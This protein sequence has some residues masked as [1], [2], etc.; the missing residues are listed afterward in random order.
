MSLNPNGAPAGYYYQAGATAYLVDPAGTYSVAGATAPTTD[1]VGAYSGAGASAPTLAAAGTYIPVTGATS[2][3]EAIVDPAGT[4]SAAAASAP[5]T[6]PTGTYSALGASAPTPAAPGAYIPAAGA[7]SAG[8]QTYSPPGTYR[9]PGASAPIADPGGT[10]SGPDATAPTMDPAGT[11]SSSYA[12]DRVFLEGKNLTPANTVLAFNNATAVANYYGATSKEA[13]QAKEFFAGYGN[14]SA[15]MLFTRYSATR[16]PHLLGANI[17]GLTLSQL[18]SISGSLALTFQGYTYSGSINLAQ[19]QSFSEV[20]RT[21]QTAL[22]KN[23]QFAA[24]TEGSSITPVSVT[25]TGSI[26]GELLDVTSISSGSIELGAEISGSGVP[27]GNQ[28]VTQLNGTPGGPGLYSF[29]QGEGNVSSET[30]TESYGVLTVGTVESGTVGVGQFVTGT[31]VLPL[32]AIDGNLSGSGPGSTWLVN[33]AQMVAGESMTMTAPPITVI[34]NR[35]GKT[36]TGATENNDFFDVT[37]NGEF[38]YDNNSGSLSFMSGTA[39]AALGLTQASGAIDS[40]PGGLH[41]SPAQVMNLIVQ[42]EDSQFGSFQSNNGFRPGLAAWAQSTDGVYTFLGQTTDTLPAG[43]SLPT[44]DPAGTYSGPGASAPTPAAPGTYIPVTGATSSA[45]EITDS[46]GTYSLAGAS[47]PTLARPGFYVPTA[48][49]SFETPVSPGYYQPHAGATRE[50]L[51][52]APTI[53]GT[54]AGQSTPSGQTDAPFSS[55]TIADRNVGASD[56]LTIQITGGGG[57]L[58]DG[59]GFSGLTESTAGVYLLT[60][61]DSAI[62]SELDALV[63]TPN[64]FDATTTFTLAD[65]T[66]LGTTSGANANTTVT[67]TNG[68][69]VYSVS[70]F[71]ADQTILDLIPGGF[72]I[73]DTAADISSDLDQ[74]DDSHIDAIAISDNGEVSASV[75]QLTNDKTAIGKLQNANLST[76]LLAIQDT[77]ADVQAGLST[78]VAKSTE[79]ASITASNGPVVVSA[80]TVQADQPALDKIVGGFAVSDTANDVVANLNQLNDP[81]IS[82][83]TISDNGQISVS[84]AQLTADATAIGKLENANAS[85]VLLAINDTAGDVQTGLST[86][87]QDTGEISSIT[88]SYGPIVVSA[89]TFSADQSTLDKI[90]GGF[91][92]SDAA[93]NLVADLSALNADPN[94]EG[95]TADIGEA[96]LSGGVGVNASNFSE[97][98]AGTSLTLDENLNY[99]G[100]FSQGAA[101]TIAISAGDTLSLTGTTSLGGTTSGAGTLAL[102]GGSTTIDSGA[103]LAVSVS[104]WSIS[105]AGADVTLD[106]NLT[107][108]GSFSERAGDTFVLSGGHL[109]LSGAAAFSGG[110]VDGSNF[111]LT[112]G[113]TAVS[114]LTIGGTVEWENTNTVNESAGSATIGDASGDEAIL[115]NTPNGTYD[116]LDNSGIGLGASTASYIHDGGLFEKTGGAGTS[117]IAPSFSEAATGTVTVAS[118]TLSFSGPENSFAG[119]ITGAGTLQLAGGDNTLSGGAAILVSNLSIS[120]SDTSVTI[121]KPLNYAGAFSEAAGGTLALTGGALVLTGANNVFSGGTV[122]GSMFLYTE[123]TAAVSGLTI[124][125][126][127]EWENTNA[128]NQSGGNVTLGDNISTDEAILYNTPK[129]TYD[130]LDNSD[131]GLGASTASYIHNGGLFEKTGGTGTSAIAPAMTNTGTIEVAAATLDMQGAVTGTGSDEISGASTLE[132]DSTVAAGQTVGFTGSGGTLNLTAPQGFAGE[133]SGFDTVGANDAIEVAS[134]WAFSGFTENAKGTQGTL[135]FATGA[136][137]ISLTLL[138]DYNPA[139]FAHQTLANGSTLITYT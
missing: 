54:M 125:G 8:P 22:N 64:N 89:A 67:V 46:P 27:A 14:T 75:Q 91:D 16:R 21:I 36:I 110:T 84:V 61:T 59:A 108:A 32:T 66:S 129:G 112:E 28:I 44:T 62:T 128:V 20:A 117:V 82:A 90:F 136:S 85:A 34:L 88:N 71:E 6:D 103:T 25:F 39:A 80:A 95:I 29:F 31:D 42:T 77:A 134:P 51:A 93:A 137:T 37:P 113:T 107:Y 98:G 60:G 53:S 94:V 47:A 15:T 12:L 111:L 123:G 109:L 131:I 4:Y 130:I 126:I 55:V 38:G 24:V 83:I 121:A 135:G 1:P 5:T 43:S 65:T 23:L 17:G 57:A 74:L 50:L 56:S 120:G 13:A 40:S 45:A 86:L 19:V 92:V 105:G 26:N 102:A 100:T 48:G 58:A 106:E 78:L 127:V 18:Q 33:N 132:F 119:A 70:T 87:V 97:L 139:D 76:V 99:A 96:T 68:Q 69:Q 133:I 124:G 138:G 73:L 63:F 49:A 104:N 72:D 52:V 11:Y 116:I 81:N 3:A 101:S 41:V 10:Y 79:I 118:G 2:E 9:P 30:M 122:D 115:Y 35:D 7:I 114:G